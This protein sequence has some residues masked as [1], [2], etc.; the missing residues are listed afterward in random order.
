VELTQR[1]W[2]LTA[3]EEKARISE[4]VFAKVSAD[5]DPNG[6]RTRLLQKSTLA[7]WRLILLVPST[8]SASTRL[9]RRRRSSSMG[10]SGT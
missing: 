4:K 6:P 8:H 2:T 5:L 1:E 9:W 10:E 7:S 3:Q